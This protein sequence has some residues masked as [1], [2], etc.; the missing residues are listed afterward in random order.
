MDTDAIRPI[1]KRMRR[2]EVP[3]GTRFVTFSCQRRLPLLGHPS[4]RDLFAC[5]LAAARRE[6][7]FELFAWVV[8]PEHAHLVV[9]PR[10]EARLDEALRS[11]KTSVARLVVARWR[12]IDAPILERL[13]TGRGP[14]RY[15]QKGGGF[16]RNVRDLGEFCREV[17]YVHRNPVEQELVR[18]PEDWK[19][20]SVRWWMGL[21]EGEIEC[22]SPP[23]DPRSWEMWQGYK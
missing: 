5:Q 21:R 22:E 7:G 2:R 20:S 19:W 11:L 15:W 17:R 8:M 12:E 10:R 14:V 3:G 13:R 23:G 4:I 9:R 6:H 18:N 16:D 1:R